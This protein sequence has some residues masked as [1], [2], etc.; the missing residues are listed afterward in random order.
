MTRKANLILLII[1][2]LF[3]AALASRN[4]SFALMAVPF[5]IYLGLGLFASPDTLSLRANRHLDHVRSRVDSPVRMTIQISNDGESTACLR[6]HELMKLNQSDLDTQT[7]DW[8][9]LPSQQE[10]EF[11]YTIQAP[12]G[13]YEW[14]QVVVTASDPFG[15]F[16]KTHHLRA[17]AHLVVVTEPP[18][19]RRFAFHPKTT[20]HTPGPN[21]SR[22][23]GCGT[24]FWGV[25]EYHPGDSQRL[26]H[27]RLAARH[28]NQLFS[29]EFEREEMAD[30]GLILDTRISNPRPKD[31]GEFFDHSVQATAALAKS[32]LRMGNRVSLLAL[33][34]RVIR[35]FPGYG[36]RQL[37]NILDQLADCQP[38]ENISLDTLRYF[39]V[40]LFPSHAM[41]VLISPLQ[42]QDFKTIAR[43]RSEGYQLMVV[44][45]NPVH[46]IIRERLKDSPDPLAQR[47]LLLERRIL[48]W[49]IKQLGV[50]VIDWMVDRSL[51]QAI[52][53]RKAR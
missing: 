32:F 38:A 41:I 23:P 20:I 5:L 29:K 22:L 35:V 47:M 14:Q 21:L 27:W 4:G 1:T 6:I 17:S 2:I 49:R 12:R 3:L 11:A 28:R 26:I 19:I 24:D 31:N 8:F 16:E 52:L 7:S 44:S 15:L 36:K 40:R 42:T 51:E 48:L 45:P 37:V 18:K 50:D 53:A 33:G 30:I 9:C 34:E 43:L 10:A 46:F 25:R 13:R 39:P